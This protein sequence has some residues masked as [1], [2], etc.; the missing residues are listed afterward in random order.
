M[1]GVVLKKTNTGVIYGFSANNHGDGI[2][3]AAVSALVLN[4]VNSIERFTDDK[5]ICDYDK[6]GG[7]FEFEH[8][9]LKNG[10]ASHDASLLLESMALGLRGVMEEYGKEIKIVEEVTT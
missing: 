6:S 9:L 4:A 2:V 7:R 1:I 10:G 8:T 3:C 5:F